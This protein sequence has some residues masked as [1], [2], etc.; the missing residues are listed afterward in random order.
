VKSHVMLKGF[1]DQPMMGSKLQPSQ[2]KKAKIIKYANETIWLS[3][4]VSS[5]V[6]VL[7][8]SVGVKNTLRRTKKTSSGN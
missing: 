5:R 8:P 2:L 6:T 4:S 1:M 7:E 3:H